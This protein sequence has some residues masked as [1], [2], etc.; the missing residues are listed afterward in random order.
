MPSQPITDEGASAATTPT[1]VPTDGAEAGAAE[2]KAT[3]QSG[4]NTVRAGTKS[5]QSRQLTGWKAKLPLP[6]RIMWRAWTR[7]GDA[8]GGLLAAGVA[9][10]GLLSVFPGITAA[11]ALFGLIADPAMITS[12]SAWL[13]GLLPP[14]AAEL[15]NQQLVQ[16]AGARPESLG[17]AAAISAAVALWSASRATDSVIQGLNVIFGTKEGRSFIVLKAMTVAITFVAIVG[18]LLLLLI[19]AAIPA[20][21][22]LIGDSRLLTL[23]TQVLRWP[24]MFGVGIAGIS[25]LYRFG[26][27]RTG[28]SWHLITPGAVFSCTLWVVGSIGFSLYVQAFG[29][30]NE[31]FGTLSGVIVLLTWMWLSAFVILF[32]AGVDAERRDMVQPDPAGK[33]ARDK[34]S[35]LNDPASGTSQAA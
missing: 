19:V 17:W 28:D 16:V 3:S 30:Y 9:F 31:T 12:Q 13:T 6:L 5:H 10:Y 18:A 25:L 32:G 2:V 15:V 24:L 8:H 35:D 20:V 14:A 7:M 23:L 21:V 22:A 1:V 4:H 33:V 34:T 26:P 11:V 29:S 27:D